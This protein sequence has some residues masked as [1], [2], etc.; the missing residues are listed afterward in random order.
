MNT[1]KDNTKESQTMEEGQIQVADLGE[2]IENLQKQTMRDTKSY[3]ASLKEIIKRIK[4][5]TPEDR[6]DYAKALNLCFNGGI[7]SL[8]GWKAWVGDIDNIAELS[9][10]ELQKVYP[11]VK[12][13]ILALLEIDIEIT[14]R[15]LTETAVKVSK[16]KSQ[17]KD[18][19]KK[20]TTYVA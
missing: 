3:I 4:E 2:M 14:E 9:L 15:K 12:E 20:T 16:S 10:E 6:V 5:A 1:D 11:Q 17:R 7:L 18:N 19:G 13:H 8:N